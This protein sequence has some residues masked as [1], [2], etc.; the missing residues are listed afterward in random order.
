MIGHDY[1]PSFYRRRQR[2]F[3]NR[4]WQLTI[5]GLILGATGAL[6]AITILGLFGAL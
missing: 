2:H 4:L 6:G 1:H 5:T 3:Y